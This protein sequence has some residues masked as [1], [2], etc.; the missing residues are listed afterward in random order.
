D[1]GI[2]SGIIGPGDEVTARDHQGGAPEIA[3]GGRLNEAEREVILERE[4]AQ[5]EERRVLRVRRQAGEDGVDALRRRGRIAR[6][7]V[8]VEVL[9]REVR[10]RL[11]F[12][13]VE[14]SV[15]VQ[16]SIVQV[17]AEAERERG[18]RIADLDQVAVRR[19]RIAPDRV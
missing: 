4:L 17:L 16:R 11:S 1:L 2:Q 18:R 8:E 13:P 12:A 19:L 5:L 9:L 10:D 7:A 3:F 14:V 6:L 15:Q